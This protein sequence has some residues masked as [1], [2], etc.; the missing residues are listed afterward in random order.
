MKRIFLFLASVAI[1]LAACSSQEQQ[2]LPSAT[3]ESVGLDSEK[4]AQIDRVVEEAIDNKDIPGAVVGIVRHGKMAFLKAYGNKSVV[5]DTVAMTTET[6]FDMA[7][8]SK[9]IGTTLSFMQLVENGYVRLSDDVKRY[10]PDFKPWVDPQTG[11]KVDITVRQLLTHSSGLDPYIGVSAFVSEYGESNPDSLMT[12][13]AT[14]VGRNFRPGTEFLYSCL[15]FVTL[16]NILQKVTGERLCDYAQKNVFDVL[17]LKHT[18]YFPLPT[19]S[20]T[21][22]GEPSCPNADEIAA[23]CAPTEVQEDGLP[24]VA[25][26]HDPIA[27]VINCGN[28]GNA[29]VFTNAEDLA[30]ILA[31]LMNGGEWNGKRIL[32]RNTVRT[33]FTVPPEDDPAVGRALGWDCRSSH[34]GP[35]GDLLSRD[36]SFMHTG[37]TGTSAVMDLDNDV[38]VIVL[39]HRVH[40]KDTGGVGRLRAQIANITAGALLD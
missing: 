7:S 31:C 2:G 35:K 24:L 10:I 39:T 12:Y 20:K 37:Y 15:N 36:R 33:M 16:Q 34:S 22:S 21:I 32:S 23:L 38:A 14:R 9:C 19:A 18:C 11:K 8:L 5:P 28:S 13:I 29:G 26:V 1:I 40:P 25:Q 30:V 4:L 3:P 27:H 17:G 6:V